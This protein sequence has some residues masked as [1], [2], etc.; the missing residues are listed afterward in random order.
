MET[1][2]DG[3][4]PK[5]IQA[6]ADAGLDR[7]WLGSGGWKGLQLRP[8]TVQKAI[9][10]GYLIG[11]YDSFHSI[12]SPRE[13]DTWE[14]AQ[15]DQKLYETGAVVRQDGTRKTGFKKKGYALSPIAARPYVEKRVSGLMRQLRCNS[16]FIDCDAFGDVFDDY[17]PLHPATQ[18]EDMRARLSRM[19]WIRDTF[20]AVIGSEGGS[21]Y[22]AGTIHFAHGMM[23]P[24]I[25]W[26]DRDLT[27]RSSQYYLGGYYPPDGP[28]AFLKQVAMKPE[29]RR[30]YAD[31]RFR[32]PLY[33]I[34][35][36]DS[37]VA[38]HQWGFGSLKFVDEGHTR[39]L[40]ELLYNVPPLYH[41]NLAEWRMR[42]AEIKTHY[43]FFSPLHGKT[44]L[45]PMTDFAWLRDD[46]LI[47]RTIFADELE[48]VANFST[49][50]CS[51]QGSTIP[52]HSIIAKWP[53]SGEVR[54]H[55][56]SP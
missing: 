2:G 44:G 23:T 14:T 54:L 3:L 46:R 28:A 8:D 51:Y 31:P 12:H 6:L 47:Q 27:D 4:S 18:E 41:L 13:A 37:V 56:L 16:W 5:M 35:L 33:E 25:G 20:G 29:H 49:D 32:L 9:S 48:L 26:G 39:E 17:S 19:A 24:G 21:S 11:P 42:K 1:W 38:T 45:L 30:V 40:L 36:H 22:A 10:S 7:L 50:P 43:D 53:G 34:A 15:F 52:P 55:R